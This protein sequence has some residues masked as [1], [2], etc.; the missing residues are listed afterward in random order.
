MDVTRV[1][2]K[3]SISSFGSKHKDSGG[4]MNSV[5]SLRS[6]FLVTA[7]WLGFA[8]VTLLF[9]ALA[10]QVFSITIQNVGLSSE[11]GGIMLT[12]AAIS[13]FCASN[14]KQFGAL[15]LI[16]AL[17]LILNALI[18]IYYV[19]NGHYSFGTAAFNI[20]LNPILALWFWFCRPTN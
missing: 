18:N 5:I 16:F 15:W 4:L 3:H 8:G 9:P 14:T 11:F 2:T 7:V 19:L 10:S 13:L 6:V 17:G 12:I 20:I 1:L